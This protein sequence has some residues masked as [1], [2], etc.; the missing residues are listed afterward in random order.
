[1]MIYR[2]ICI[3]LIIIGIL[4]IIIKDCLIKKNNNKP[5]SKNKKN[6]NICI[7]IPAKDESSVIEGLLYSI[8]KQTFSI[9][10]EDVYV[11]VEDK[12]DK[13]VGITKDYGATVF[14]RKKLNLKRKGYAIDECL[15]EIL[16]NN[17]Q[18]DMYFIFDAD[19]ILDESFISN[20][21]PVYNNGYDIASG[22]RD[23]KN[24]NKS[25]IAGVSS[26]TFSLINTLF[27]K[28]KIK[29]TRNITFS[30]TGLY[31]KGD[32][33]KKWNGYPFHSLTEDYEL[34]IYAT[35]HSLTTY[36]N[37]KSVF[38]DEQPVTYIDT[39]KQRIRWIRGFFDVRKT[40]LSE[41]KKSI[42]KH[43]NNYG[44]KIDE[45]IGVTP[46]VFLIVGYLLWII[47]SLVFSFINNNFWE[48]I[49]LLLFL[50]FILF[51]CTLI[52]LILE[53]NMISINNKMKIK[54][55][56]FNPLFTF[57]Y[58]PCAI[59]ALLKKEVSWDKIKHGN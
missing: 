43:D 57:T 22:Y 36:Y 29:E 41:L 2:V 58:I 56:F 1:M 55:L 52:L 38:Y 32:L 13:T 4:I 59:K 51:I 10:M 31:I 46:Y 50:Y 54:I 21:I 28:R 8:K 23:S 12:N 6:P 44:S 19:N 18:Y 24:G 48:P 30:G 7:L 15:K 20:M 34:S 16:N 14:V 3:I 35:I 27:N 33:I 45:I 39:V 49:L 5:V 17:K 40:Y 26:M 11:I 25:V 37:D 53:K 42:N 47:I 9:N